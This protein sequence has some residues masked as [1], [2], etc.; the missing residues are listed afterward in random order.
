MR[1]RKIR[2]DKT[3]LNCGYN[4]EKYYCTNCGQENIEVRRSFFRLFKDFVEYIVHFDNSW[5][6]TLKSLLLNPGM[7]TKE[8][9]GGRRQRYVDPIKLYFLVSFACFLIIPALPDF[10]GEK[11]GIITISSSNNLFADQQEKTD[12]ISNLD[13]QLS[14]ALL[15]SLQAL[16]EDKRMPSVQ[17]YSLRK[18]A[19]FREK[20]K[21]MQD[22]K[23]ALKDNFPHVLFL[24]MPAFACLLW[25]FNDKKRWLFYDSGIFTLHLISFV[26]F[27]ITLYAILESLLSISSGIFFEVLK[28]LNGLALLCYPAVYFYIG[29]K[30]MY[31]GRRLVNFTKCTA[32]IFINSILLVL[33]LI[34]YTLFTLWILAEFG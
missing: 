21:T 29:Y 3:C 2:D 31:N 32:L 4:V 7:L 33:L 5:W 12:T 9:L 20:G 27:Y 1:I 14:I 24:Y 23:E 6:T 34:A 30:R 8:Y 22:F 18:V 19:Q 26:L 17:D 15:D 13:D 28:T 25:L 11:K 16:P 10:S